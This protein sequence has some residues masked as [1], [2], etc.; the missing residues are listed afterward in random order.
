MYA[1]L[2]LFYNTPGNQQLAVKQVRR[3]PKSVHVC[4]VCPCRVP[5]AAS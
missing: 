1:V 3:L 4:G 2:L 5:L